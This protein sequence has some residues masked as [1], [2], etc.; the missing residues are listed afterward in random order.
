MSTCARWAS[1]LLV[2][3]AGCGVPSPAANPGFRL[4]EAGAAP[5]AGEEVLPA[6]LE[7]LPFVHRLI[8]IRARGKRAVCPAL[9]DAARNWLQTNAEALEGVV[10]ADPASEGRWRF[11]R[12]GSVV[13]AVLL[14][15]E[16]ELFL[17]ATLAIPTAKFQPKP[18]S[19][20]RIL[21]QTRG[22][23]GITRDFV[24]GRLVCELSPD[25]ALR[26]FREPAL[27]LAIELD[28]R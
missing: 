15:M 17:P 23:T 1:S 10:P 22:I 5:A 8:D 24:N 26:T 16:D 20:P 14:R 25:L 3:A 12:R 19:A 11:L 21:G 18:G 13:Y 4:L 9:P 27:V 6:D 2:L 28:L 7:A